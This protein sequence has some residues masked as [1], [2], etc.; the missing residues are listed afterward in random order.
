MNAD[1]ANT[2]ADSP[3]RQQPFL[4]T[5]MARLESTDGTEHVLAQLASL[6]MLVVPSRMQFLL[7]GSV[8]T[9]TDPYAKQ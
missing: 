3:M 7:A 6:A 8:T 5:L 1:D 9:L 2:V 4:Q